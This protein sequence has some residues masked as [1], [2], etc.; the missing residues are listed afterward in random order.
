[1]QGSARSV[2]SSSVQGTCEGAYGL[3]Y[4]LMLRNSDVFVHVCVMLNSRG[5]GCTVL[6]YCDS[7]V[8]EKDW[9]YRKRGM[10]GI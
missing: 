1:M 2:W 4:G 9:R 7:I 3:G 6:G 5:G 8:R 10:Q